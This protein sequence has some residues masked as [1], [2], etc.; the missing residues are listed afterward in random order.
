[1]R[2]RTLHS[3]DVTPKEAV[4]LQRELAGRIDTRTPLE[5]W[6]LIAGVDIS[7]SRHSNT[8]YAG[9]VVLRRDDLRVVEEQTAVR[10]AKFPY[11]P[12]LLSFRE[13][14]PVLDALAKIRTRPDVVMFDGQGLAH[15]RRIG[16]ASHAGLCLD[17]PTLGCA[18]SLL[19]GEFGR[20]GKTAGAIAELVHREEVVGMAV[21]TRTSVQPVY[22]SVGHGIDLASA[23]R[24]VLQTCRGYRIPEPTR[25]AH[26]LVNALRTAAA[27]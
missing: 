12:G 13:I 17:V 22:V 16:Y 11:V 25:Q 9:A 6:E 8:L 10:E 15:P 2:V 27:C 5:D 24:V 4:A 7:Y 1:M 14:P 26:R 18:K 23:V 20:L 21:R 19:C 3:W